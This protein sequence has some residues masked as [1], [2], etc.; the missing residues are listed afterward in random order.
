MNTKLVQIYSYEYLQMQRTT[1]TCEE[2]PSPI[3]LSTSKSQ[4]D[5]T[6]KT[7]NIRKSTNMVNLILCL[8]C[9]SILMS[10]LAY[11]QVFP[12]VFNK[13]QDPTCSLDMILY[14]RVPLDFYILPWC[15]RH[16]L[17]SSIR[18]LIILAFQICSVILVLIFLHIQSNYNC[19]TGLVLV[20]KVKTITQLN[21]SVTQS[22]CTQNTAKFSIP[23]VHLV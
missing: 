6:R 23:E 18:T 4:I 16:T 15:A 1:S 2:L 7:M 17:P 9:V 8:L 14:I 10:I 21:R 5:T 20:Q 22:Q 19:G 11:I 3:Y 12:T 13:C